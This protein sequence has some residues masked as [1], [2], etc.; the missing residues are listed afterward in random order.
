[1]PRRYLY[2][3]AGI[4]LVPLVALACSNS[5]NSPRTEVAITQTDDGCT[6]TSVN[7][8]PGEKLRLAVRNDGKKD[9]EVEGTEGTKLEEVLVPAGRTRNVDYT[10]PNNK[11]VRKIKCYIP[12]GSTTIIQLVPGA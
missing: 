1:M 3:L 12:G 8:S 9:H 6:P 4:V 2:L 7:V 5:D 10:V 11:D